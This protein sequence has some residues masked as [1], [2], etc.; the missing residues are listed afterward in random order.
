MKIIAR[1]LAIAMLLTVASSRVA[2]GWS[3]YVSPEDVVVQDELVGIGTFAA[4]TVITFLP[5][6]ARAI[7]IERTQYFVSGGNWFLA[8]AREGVKYLV[9]LAPV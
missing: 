2:F 5:D 1:Y 8:I 3:Y 6:G 9:V 4:G 7:I